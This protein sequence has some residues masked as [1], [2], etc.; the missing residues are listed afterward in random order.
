MEHQS[1]LKR[2]GYIRPLNHL[3]HRVKS[4]NGCNKRCSWRLWMKWRSLQVKRLRN[5]KHNFKSFLK[6]ERNQLSKQWGTEDPYV[7]L[8][9]LVL[10][11]WVRVSILVNRTSPLPQGQ[12][13]PPVGLPLLYFTSTN[14]VTHKVTTT[15]RRIAETLRVIEAREEQRPSLYG[16]SLRVTSKWKFCYVKYTLSVKIY[17]EYRWLSLFVKTCLC[18]IA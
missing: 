3:D 12:M 8:D 14:P 13:R 17:E 6:N 2:V 9:M 18:L 16:Q 11:W 1:K 10:G 7:C 4:N 15:D 5:S